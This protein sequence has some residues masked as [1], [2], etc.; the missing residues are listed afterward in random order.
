MG[1]GEDI[2]NRILGTV[3]EGVVELP[4]E[5]LAVEGLDAGDVYG[6]NLSP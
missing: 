1:L 2:L 4:T 5:D 3:L 6:G